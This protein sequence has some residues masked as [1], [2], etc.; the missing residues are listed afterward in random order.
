MIWEAFEVQMDTAT[1]WKE[2]FSVNLRRCAF[3]SRNVQV[4][5]FARKYNV[6]DNEKYSIKTSH[7]RYL[8]AV[9]KIFDTFKP[10]LTCSTN[11]WDC[12]EGFTKHSLGDQPRSY[13]CTENVAKK[14]LSLS[15]QDYSCQLLS[16]DKVDIQR[17]QWQ[18]NPK[19][20][21]VKTM[22]LQD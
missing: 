7:V 10:G 12:R 3:H 8:I 21:G 9:R 1:H 19:A 16:I 13:Q 17:E 14:S 5:R 2:T 15:G 6:V 18:K 22:L 4:L 11:E 20:E